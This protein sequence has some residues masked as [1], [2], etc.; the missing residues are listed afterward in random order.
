MVTDSVFSDGGCTGRLGL[1]DEE[2]AATEVVLAEPVPRTEP[3]SEDQVTDERAF[4]NAM[5]TARALG[6]N[7]DGLAAFLEG[8][9]LSRGGCNS[10]SDVEDVW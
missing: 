4:E 8:F 9:W 7:D 5:Q 10:R 1:L 2:A 3:A 6:L